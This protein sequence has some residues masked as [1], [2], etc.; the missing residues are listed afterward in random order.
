MERDF[1][2]IKKNAE[3]L[4]ENIEALNKEIISFKD[5]N[6]SL[7]Y[8]ASSIAE[9]CDSLSLMVSNSSEILREV[10]S[11]SVEKTLKELRNSAESMQSV[12]KEIAQSNNSTITEMLSS[13][14]ETISEV[15]S[16]NN[17]IVERIEKRHRIMGIIAVICSALSLFITFM[18]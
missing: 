15:I 16:L 11:L 9:T 12:S 1:S 5:A 13:N 18:R 4:V 10:Q 6:N 7:E 17:G 3:E 2:E 8:V 14:S